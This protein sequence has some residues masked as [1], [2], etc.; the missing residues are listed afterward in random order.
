MN[1]LLEPPVSTQ[2]MSRKQPKPAPKRRPLLQVPLD[3]TLDAKF[4][5]Y[6]EMGISRAAIGKLLVTA[7]SVEAAV[8]VLASKLAGGQPPPEGPKGKTGK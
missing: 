2:F 4:S 8:R 5:G 3:D 7:E 1:E 6:E